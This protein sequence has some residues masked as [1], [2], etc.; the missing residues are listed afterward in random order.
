MKYDEYTPYVNL[1]NA[2]IEQAASDLKYSV[3]KYL[4][5]KNNLHD[6][7]VMRE[8]LRFFY[9]DYFRMLTNVAPEVVLM[10]VLNE[11]TERKRNNKQK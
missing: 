11:A 1:A 6:D 5:N 9:S 8:V 2:I 7:K 3:K 10:E 4:K